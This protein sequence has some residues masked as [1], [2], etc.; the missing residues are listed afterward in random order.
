[1]VFLPLVVDDVPWP[2]HT[3]S[4]KSLPPFFFAKVVD[5]FEVGFQD[6][7][8]GVEASDERIEKLI[9]P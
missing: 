9:V 1:M 6:R 3:E 4:Q 2:I 8:L 5:L 7:Y